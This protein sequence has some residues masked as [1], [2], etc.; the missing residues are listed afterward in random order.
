MNKKVG[1]IL[2]IVLPLII[3]LLIK[4]SYNYPMRIFDNKDDTSLFINNNLSNNVTFIVNIP[5]NTPEEDII[6]MENFQPQGIKSWKMERTDQYKYKISFLPEQLEKSVDGMYHYRYVRNDLGFIGAEY[7]EPDDFEF[8]EQNLGRAIQLKKVITQEDK[9]ERWRWFPQSDISVQNTFNLVPQ[10]DWENRINNIEF[11]SGQ[12]IEDLF[13]PQQDLF[14]D[15][16]INHMKKQNCLA[17]I[18]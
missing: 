6:Y 7:F 17:F 15:S 5:K 16:T 12:A 3:L 18:I 2:I 13:R 10:L 8:R 11:R 4:F 1:I 9:I 14:L